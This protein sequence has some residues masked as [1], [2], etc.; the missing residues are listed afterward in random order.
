[1]MVPANFTAL[2]EKVRPAVVNIRT[3][4]TVDGGERNVPALSTRAAGDQEDPFRDFF[5]RFFGDDP[6]R[7]FKQR[8]LGSGFIIDRAAMW[9]P[10]TTWSRP[11]TR[12]RSS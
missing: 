8:S 4:K 11:Q 9:S 7:Q 10:T 2:A 5:D 6:Q 3:V 1:M 12:S